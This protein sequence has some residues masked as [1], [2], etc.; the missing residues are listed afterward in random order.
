MA[1]VLVSGVLAFGWLALWFR[2]VM[3]VRSSAQ[4]ARDLIAAGRYDQAGVFLEK[5]LKERPNS[6]E[7]R[8][9]AARGAIGLGRLDAGLSELEAARR[10][11][12]PAEAVDRQ[13][14]IALSRMGL[15]NEAEPLLRKV[16]LA[17]PN[18]GF[19]DPEVDEALTRCYLETFQLRAAHE[20]IKRWLRDDPQSAQAYYWKAEVQRREADVDPDTLIPL[21]QRVTQLDPD[22]EKARLALAEQY[23]KTHRDDLAAQEY[24]AALERNST[25]VEARLGL[26]EIAAKR[27][28]E[29]EAIRLFDRAAELAPRDFR[30][31]AERGKIEIRH[32]R[33][34]AALE[35]FD[36]ALAI[37][38]TEPE[39]HYQRSLI[40]AQLGRG[41]E[42][43]KEQS[44]ATR[45]R[46][47]KDE[48]AKLLK[49]L[50][51]SPA[52]VE[53][54]LK[55]ARWLFDRD[56]PEEGKRWAEKILR[57]H[58]QQPE[59]NNLLANHYEKL[60]NHG[61]ANFYRAR[62]GAR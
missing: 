33:F 42:A 44:E 31:L 47:E 61:L 58:P 13:K 62:A 6:A 29:D 7:A 48:L 39:V 51:K 56:H 60:G 14:G 34:A 1:L 41:D 15:L 53:L 59:A 28:R 17:H 45:L 49:D 23:L 36:R 4:A 10:L 18:D 19:S 9:L 25:N 37:D 27:G 5:W 35:F 8:F 38:S 2:D 21:Y 55:A 11:G 16:F 22:H 40:L 57:E 20:V 30:P 24:A 52:D 54:Q 50:L 43:R 3:E 46:A 32:A 26:G 12:H